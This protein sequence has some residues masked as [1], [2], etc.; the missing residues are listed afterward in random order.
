MLTI[1]SEFSLFGGSEKKETK[2]IKSSTAS[3]TPKTFKGTVETKFFIF[4]YV[5]KLKPM[6][7]SVGDINEQ[8]VHR[9]V[10]YVI[11][12]IC[13]DKS[14]P[15]KTPK[16]FAQ[17]FGLFLK[18]YPIYLAEGINK[19]FGKVRVEECGFDLIKQK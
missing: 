15:L 16:G 12:Q 8:N 2:K 14:S 17:N 18:Y 7:K 11:R 19:I 6:D 9:I 5:V 13:D 1:L 3:T 4:K 10:D